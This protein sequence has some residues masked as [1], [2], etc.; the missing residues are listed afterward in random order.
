MLCKRHGTGVK[1]AVDHL[2][3]TVHLFAA[4]WAADGDIVNVWPVQLNVIRTV[5]GHCL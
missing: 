2:R 1:P 3:H 4:F 5:V